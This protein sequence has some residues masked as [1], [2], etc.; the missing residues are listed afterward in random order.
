MKALRIESS[1]RQFFD[2]YIPDFFP[3]L[4]IDT[5][6]LHRLDSRL[7]RWWQ[8][9]EQPHILRVLNENPVI[10]EAG[11]SAANAAD[12]V[13]AGEDSMLKIG[14]GD[15]KDAAEKANNE[16]MKEWNEM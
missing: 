4:K 2:I 9:V 7:R 15:K 11:E 3:R 13:K 14:L 12:D 10:L 6:L 5:T 16:L 1:G 8:K